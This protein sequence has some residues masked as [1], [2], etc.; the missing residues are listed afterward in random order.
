LR[1]TLEIHRF[2]AFCG[3]TVA[4]RYV[5]QPFF[6]R[7]LLSN[8]AHARNP[9]GDRVLWFRKA[10][11]SFSAGAL[12]AAGG[13]KLLNSRQAGDAGRT[14]DLTLFALTR[15]VDIIVGELWQK[16]K[17]RRKS[18]GKFTAVESSIRHVA[19]SAVFAVSSGIIMY[20]WIYSREKLPTYAKPSSLPPF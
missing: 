2:P 6:E 13:L 8:M 19:D 1:Q 15:A 17:E 3:F 11:A 12:A 20:A 5:L 18:S 9:A 7:L 10:V 16:R 4:L 14:L